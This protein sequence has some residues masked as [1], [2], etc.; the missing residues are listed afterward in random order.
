MSACT[1]SPDWGALDEHCGV[2]ESADAAGERKR[3]WLASLLPSDPVERRVLAT[4][5]V[6]RL[7]L[8]PMASIAIVAGVTLLPVLL[9]GV[10][11]LCLKRVL[12]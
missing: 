7:L 11:H 4:V 2:A 1:L 5:A 6:V 10:R 9:F 12:Q 8:M 3:G